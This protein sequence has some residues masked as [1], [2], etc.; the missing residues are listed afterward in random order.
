MCVKLEIT[1]NMGDLYSFI[2][3]SE[4]YEVR[5]ASWFMKD[6]LKML[7]LNGRVFFVG[8]DFTVFTVT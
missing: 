4:N 8:E 5:M 2:V 7:G 3:D 6:T 1:E